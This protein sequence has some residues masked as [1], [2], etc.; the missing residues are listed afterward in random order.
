MQGQTASARVPA[1]PRLACVLL[2][3]AAVWTGFVWHYHQAIDH[4]LDSSFVPRLGFWC[5]VFATLS[6]WFRRNLLPLYTEAVR[7][8][9]LGV[10]LGLWAIPWLPTGLSAEMAYGL[11]LIATALVV[12]GALGGKWLRF[13]SSALV[14]L[15]ALPLLS[16][17]PQSVLV[18]QLQ[19]LAAAVARGF[20][21]W[22]GAEA[23]VQHGRV[24]FV[25]P[26]EAD[27]GT[28][29]MLAIA[30]ECSGY[31]SL[32]GLLLLALLLGS[33]PA[34]GIRGKAALAAWAIAVAIVA[35]LARVC[36]GIFLH[37]VGAENWAG[38]VGHAM[39]GQVILLAGAGLVWL[40][41]RRLK[42]RGPAPS[43]SIGGIC[44]DDTKNKLSAALPAP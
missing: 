9:L 19:D 12:R 36:C 32:C 34:I 6:L 5:I 2:L 41:Y 43:D 20:S 1:W 30:A 11:G 4:G 3:I 37:Y 33:S 28:P 42:I 40:C 23:I 8:P 10:G 35:N 31:R 18:Q 13:V 22:I 44:H 26:P 21:G 17:G 16:A 38:G 15:G 29:V 24:L 7:W 39:F 27:G 14:I 25:T